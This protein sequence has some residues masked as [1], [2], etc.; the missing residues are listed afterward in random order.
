[1]RFVAIAVSVVFVAMRTEGWSWWGSDDTVQEE[2]AL[3]PE[4]QDISP[5]VCSNS[6]VLSLKMDCSEVLDESE[7]ARVFSA[8][9]PIKAFDKLTISHNQFLT[10]LPDGVFGEVSFTNI[11][12]TGGV[13]ESVGEAALTSSFNTAERLMFNG[14]RIS[15]FPFH[16]LSNFSKLTSMSLAY[17]NLNELPDLSSDT[18]ENLYINNNPLGNVAASTFMGTPAISVVYLQE[19]ELQQI[20]PGTF[21]NLSHLSTVYLFRNSLTEVPASAVEFPSDQGSVYLSLNNIS[22]VAPNAFPGLTGGTVEVQRNELTELPEEVWRPLLEEGVNIT[23]WGNP[24]VCGCDIA[25]LL[26]TSFIAQIDPMFTTCED[27][28]KLALLDPADYA[29]C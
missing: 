26:N 16:I 5:C 12:V 6:S 9:F 7:L 23:P 22:K 21:S 17:N 20:I 25:W 24:L 18:L 8:F 10:T 11:Y 4:P 27:G 14:N 19:T 13:L 15:N 1:M 3:C 29:D 2:A 28:R